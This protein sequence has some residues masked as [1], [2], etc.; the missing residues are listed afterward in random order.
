[1]TDQPTAPNQRTFG[2]N[3]REFHEAV[4]EPKPNVWGPRVPGH[5]NAESRA[6]IAGIEWA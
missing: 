3:G 2:L 1:M 4:T 6:V 5:K